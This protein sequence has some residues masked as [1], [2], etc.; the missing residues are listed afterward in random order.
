MSFTHWMQRHH[1]FIL[2][3][4][5]VL[6]VG[7]IVVS[8]QMPVALFPHVD[9]PRVVISL[10]AGDRPAD[11]MVI[12]VTQP[13]EEAIRAVPGVRSVRSTT[14]RGSA[15]ISVNF[16]WGEDMVSA[17]LQVES[18]INQ[19]RSSLPPGTSFT[20]RRMD[21]TVFP[22]LAYSLTSD[23]LSLVELRDIALYQLRPLLSTV[24]GVAKIGVQGG[25]EAEYQVMVDPDRIDALGLTIDDVARALSA[26][27]VIQAVGRMED[28][29]KLYLGISDTRLRGLKDIEETIVRSGEDG[30]CAL[31][32]LQPCLRQLA[33]S[34]YG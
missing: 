32:T 6:S 8:F 1:R 17:M 25:A 5:T 24:R 13:V 21:P 30:L 7:G 19:V 34:G 29:Y 4:I 20:V 33:L 18:Y 14:S 11:Q 3:L 9:F 10:E 26:S 16:D 23:K 2:F 31:K 27:N 22:V 28:H 12:E 15:D